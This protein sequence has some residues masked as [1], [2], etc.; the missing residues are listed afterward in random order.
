VDLVIS[1]HQTNF[2]HAA[3]TYIYWGSA[4]GFSRQRRAHLPTI[5]VHLDS[6]VKAGN[7]YH[8]K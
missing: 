6:M 3:G 4:E 7:I 5:G 2:D 1:N 8:R